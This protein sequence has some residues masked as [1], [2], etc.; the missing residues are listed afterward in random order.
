M[1]SQDTINK[2]WKRYRRQMKLACTRKD[3]NGVKAIAESFENFCSDHGYPDWWA[4]I[5]R[6]RDDALLE[7]RMAQDTW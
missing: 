1:L 2:A 4:E 7:Q 3:Y 5:N 6:R